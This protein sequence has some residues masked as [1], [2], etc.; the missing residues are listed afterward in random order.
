MST[1]EYVDHDYITAE[2]GADGTLCITVG[3]TGAGE[4][5]SIVLPESERAALAAAIHTRPPFTDAEVERLAIDMYYDGEEPMPW[6][7]WDLKESLR[8]LARQR[9]NAAFGTED[10]P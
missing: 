8:A 7:D 1:Y 2:D 6:D 3:N 10:Q 9:L 5:W 4:A